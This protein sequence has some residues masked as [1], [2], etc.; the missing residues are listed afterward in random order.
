MSALTLIT[1]TGGRPEAFAFLERFIA[2]QTFNGELQWLVVDD[3][4]PATEITMRQTVIRPVPRWKPGE[5][6]LSRNLMAA[7]ALAK[8]N[9]ILFIE[10]DELYKPDYLQAMSDR[11]DLRPLAGEIPARY[12][13]VATRQ[14]R[15]IPNTTHAS[16]C[17]TGIRSELV[18]AFIKICQAGGK[19]LDIPLWKGYSGWVSPGESVVSIKGMPGRRGVGVGHRPQGG[20]WKAD[21]NLDVLRSWIGAD[22]ALYEQFAEAVAA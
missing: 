22:A 8:H 9:K 7:L 4:D 1:A 16:L 3:V 17:Q 5:I 13:N 19:F 12:Y 10:D 11:L 14:Y 18:P 2:R 15:V 6:T 20:N 21:P